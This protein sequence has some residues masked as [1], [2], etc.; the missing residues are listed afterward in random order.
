MQPECLGLLTEVRE[1][2]WWQGGQVQRPI[3]GTGPVPAFL[4]EA[5]WPELHC[6]ASQRRQLQGLQ[7]MT[8]ECST[9]PAPG[10]LS[11]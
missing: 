10:A 7:A 3:G 9:F 8:Q 11:G 6:S 5:E 4:L 2:V 1:E